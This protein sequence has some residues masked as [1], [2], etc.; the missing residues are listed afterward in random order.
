MSILTH[1]P[2]I[3]RDGLVLCLDA[4]AVRSY[5]DRLTSLP[6]PQT[7][8]L[9]TNGMPNSFSAGVA[10][11]WMGGGATNAEETTIV[12]SGSSSQ[13]S[14][15]AGATTWYSGPV[16]SLAFTA[17][18]NYRYSVWVYSATRSNPITVTIRNDSN[19][20]EALQTK[21]IPQAVWTEIAGN[22]EAGTTASAGDFLITVTGSTASDVFYFN[23]ASVLEINTWHDLSGNFNNGTLTN[24][25]SPA[26]ESGAGGTKSFDFDGT[27]DYIDIGAGLPTAPASLSVAFWVKPDSWSTDTSGWILDSAV[28]D[29]VVGTH[30]GAD[31]MYFNRDN[32]N[33][34]TYTPPTAGD[35]THVVATWTS[36]SANAVVYYNGVVQAS[37]TAANYGGIG[38]DNVIGQRS[39][40]SASNFD[41]KIA[42]F[43]IYNRVL[44]ATEAQQNYRT[45]K[46]RFGK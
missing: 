42:I 33:A 32:T 11:G 23:A 28:L 29:V 7:G 20:T 24:G 4:G 34:T 30:S 13:K 25:A 35:W 43:H 38:V 8:E 26:A 1:S 18:K 27:N 10:V 15:S 41:G 37:T 14:I 46:G 21:T 39:G 19:A 31:Y 6:Y 16:N 45:H 22:F 5:N 17:G 9:T 40:G 36:T 12:Y 3:V 2:A 44:T